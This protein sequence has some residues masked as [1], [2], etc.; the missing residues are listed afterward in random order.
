MWQAQ[1]AHEMPLSKYNPSTLACKS[2][3]SPSAK[4]STSLAAIPPRFLYAFSSMLAYP[5]QLKQQSYQKKEEKQ[6]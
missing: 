2:A 4:H 5:R 1:H 6:T 3:P